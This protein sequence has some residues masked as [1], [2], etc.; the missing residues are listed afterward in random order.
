MQKQS[1]PDFWRQG[2]KLNAG[3]APLG[4]FSENDQ[5]NI[6]TIIKGI[7]G[8]SFAGPEIYIEIKKL[9]KFDNRADV[10]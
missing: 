2:E 10:G 3:I 6:V 9:A 4:I 1:L 5:V 7:S 8:I